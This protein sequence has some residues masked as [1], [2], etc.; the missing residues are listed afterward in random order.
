M[1]LYQVDAFTDTLFSGNPAG[2]YLA[3]AFPND[4]WMQRL[5]AEMNLS[6]TAFLVPDGDGAYALRWFTPTHEVDLCGHATLASAH[7]LWTEAGAVEGTLTFDTASG[8]LTATRSGG[9]WIELDFPADPP[10]PA[11]A[12]SG[13]LDA[14]GVTDPA[15]VGR[16]NRDLFVQV[17]SPAVVD[18][19]EPDLKALSA[20]DARGIVV[21]AAAEASSEADF[22]S[23]FF[24]PAV[25]VPEDPVTGSAHCALA[26]FWTERLGRL[27]LIG[28]QTSARG[29]VV[30]TAMTAPTADRVTLAGQATTVFRAEMAG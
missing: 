4:A 26:P 23:R 2:V 1:P 18:A 17:A 14:L 28:H 25:G 15:Y 11:D 22:V 9:G 30:R 12:P 7:A 19:L 20:V 3:D 24:A 27:R 29:G 8:Q 10:L 21:T 16:S 5:A 6:E 13:F